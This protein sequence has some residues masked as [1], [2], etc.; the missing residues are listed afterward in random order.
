MLDTY[1]LT[2]DLNRCGERLELDPVA[3]LGELSDEP[4]G[5]DL[6]RQ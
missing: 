3:E 1:N 6:D 2:R 5:S 4:L